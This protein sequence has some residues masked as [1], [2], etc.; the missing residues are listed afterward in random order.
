MKLTAIAINILHKCR[1]STLIK[2]NTDYLG[3]LERQTINALGSY[4]DISYCYV[5][6]FVTMY[7]VLHCC[8]C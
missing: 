2:A 8:Q 6:L 1:F 7:S 3:S 5:L 4:H